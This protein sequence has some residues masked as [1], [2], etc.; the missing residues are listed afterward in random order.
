MWSSSRSTSMKTPRSRRHAM[1]V[2]MYIHIC[3]A[4]LPSLPPHRL[5]LTPTLILTLIALT[6]AGLRRLG[7]A[8]VPLHEE[9][10]Q[11]RRAGRCRPGKAQGDHRQAQVIKLKLSARRP[12]HPPPHPLSHVRFL[13]GIRRWL[14]VCGFLFVFKI[15]RTIPSLR[16]RENNVDQCLGC[17]GRLIST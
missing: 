7:H 1:R 17:S 3:A 5:A 12:S 13:A 4:A 16:N 9:W 8:D 14:C 15:Y 6:P 2:H 11:D 10:R